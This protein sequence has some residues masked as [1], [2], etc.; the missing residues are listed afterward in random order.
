MR[1][2]SWRLMH[3][4]LACLQFGGCMIASRSHTE[5]QEL[6]PLTTPAANLATVEIEP[7]WRMP[8]TDLSFLE[9]PRQTK[10]R[11]KTMA[12]YREMISSYLKVTSHC[13][14]EYSGI[15]S[16]VRPEYIHDGDQRAVR[17]KLRLMVI[18]EDSFWYY[19]HAVFGVLSAGIIPLRW[20]ERYQLE[21]SAWS[22]EGVPLGQTKT[23][24]NY[25]TLMGWFIV[26]IMLFRPH[27]E[28]VLG[29]TFYHMT[30]DALARL[31]E[32]GAWDRLP[33]ANAPPEP[34]PRP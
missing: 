17:L 21:L 30:L 26:P 27:H 16:E 9:Q 13:A 34:L 15:F 3:C 25:S 33:P 28:Q 18:P 29:D 14:V 32:A 7:V 12:R 2:N 24:A 1:A 19:T 6:V 31:T 4:L 10:Q 23:E 8:T 22:P 11:A 5:P 20:S